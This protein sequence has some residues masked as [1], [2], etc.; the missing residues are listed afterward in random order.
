MRGAKPNE[1]SA[2]RRRAGVD[3]SLTE[4]TS[5]ARVFSIQADGTEAWYVIT[6]YAAFVMISVPVGTD[7]I[8][9]AYD[10][11]FADDIRL[12]AYKR[13]RISFHFAPQ[14][15]YIILAE[16]VYHTAKPYIIS[17]SG[18]ISFFIQP[19]GLIMSHPTK[20]SPSRHSPLDAY[21]SVSFSTR[22][23]SSSGK[24]EIRFLISSSPP[25]KRICFLPP[26]KS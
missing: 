3:E 23:Q 13:K 22:S 10:I 7:D 8:C 17:P 25:A 6:A 4:K 26:K 11:R 2:V 19:F 21:S 1:G 9:F 18:D 20:N 15:Q 24:I 5:L 12:R 16:Q 14:E